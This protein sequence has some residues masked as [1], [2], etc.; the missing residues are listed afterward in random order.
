MNKNKIKN[1]ITD[2]AGQMFFERGSSGVSMDEIASSL[3]ISKKTLYQYFPGKKGLLYEVISTTMKENEK[4]AND[5]INDRKLNF[6][7]K[8]SRLMN[9]VS[10]IV[11]R[12]SLP[13]G[14][15]LRRNDPE[16]WKELDQFRRK[17]I[18]NNFNKLLESGIKQG[19]FR[20]DVDPQLMILMFSTLMQNLIDPKI[21]SQIP[22]TAAQ[23]FETIVEVVFRGILTEPARKDF[24]KKKKGA[25]NEN[26]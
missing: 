17:I 22:F 23:V 18:L 12:L 15:D 4:V 24:I 5:I 8:L 25:A 11:S 14:E 10:S 26:R 21:F 6:H 1:R 16:M 13:F 2:R 19:I 7:L 9:H 20:Q 3:G